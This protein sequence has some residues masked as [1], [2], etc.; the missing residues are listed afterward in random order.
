[1]WPKRR[2][3]KR[4]TMGPQT[5]PRS[6][7]RR[8]P[9]RQLGTH[10]LKNEGDRPLRPFLTQ[11]EKRRRVR[12]PP[13][14]ILGT[15]QTRQVGDVS[16][17]IELTGTNLDSNADRCAWRQ[18]DHPGRAP[19]PVEAMERGELARQDACMRQ[20]HCAKAIADDGA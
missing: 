17:R 9:L 14:E 12:G 8:A 1:M 18:V 4:L 3:Q 13:F 5:H 6:S 11:D 2:P 15:A 7:C 10:V 16:S 20:Q 19:G